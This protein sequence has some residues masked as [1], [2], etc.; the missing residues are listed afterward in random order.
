VLLGGRELTGRWDPRYG[1]KERSG[2]IR[3]GRTAA[4]ELL[5]PGDMLGVSMRADG[6]AQLS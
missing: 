6:T 1:E 5:Y 4:L 3:I 2:V